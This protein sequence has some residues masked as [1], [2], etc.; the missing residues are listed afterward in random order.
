L[1]RNIAAAAGSFGRHI[2]AMGPDEAVSCPMDIDETLCALRS[3]VSI[4]GRPSPFPHYCDQGNQ[5]CSLAVQASDGLQDSRIIKRATTDKRRNAMSGFKTWRPEYKDTTSRMLGLLRASGLPRRLECC[6]YGS[7][8]Q[9]LSM[10]RTCSSRYA[11]DII[12]A[13]RHPCYSLD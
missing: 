2:W 9:P 6:A 5:D 12:S 4:G 10:R 1:F 11:Q 3:Y 7:R 13:A 8:E